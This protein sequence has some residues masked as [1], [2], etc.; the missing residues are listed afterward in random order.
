VDLSL[1]TPPSPFAPLLGPSTAPLLLV[2]LS[3]TTHGNLK[4]NVPPSACRRLEIRVW[5]EGGE[6]LR[7]EEG[8]SAAEAEEEQDES[9]NS[10]PTRALYSAQDALVEEMLFL[11]L[12][13]EAFRS[14]GPSPVRALHGGALQWRVCAGKGGSSAH[15]VTVDMVEQEKDNGRGIGRRENR[16]EM[17]A[18]LIFLERLREG[19]WQSR[20]VKGKSAGEF[21]FDDEGEIEAETDFIAALN[22]RGELLPH[23]MS[24]AH[25]RVWVK[26]VE[27][28]LQKL[29][30]YTLT[31]LHPL[32]CP[33]CSHTFLMP[34][35]LTL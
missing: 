6:S 9:A 29:V 30:L 35:V 14:Q 25:H 23:L 27:T 19:L 3:A 32:S 2:P 8:L 24:E 10:I 21:A 33:S 22:S 13:R 28:C 17:L 18:R 12:Q 20:E 31:P 1:P 11:Q 34:C 15:I 5:E 7:T 26:K 4:V 16:L